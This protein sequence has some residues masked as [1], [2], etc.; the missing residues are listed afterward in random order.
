MQVKIYTDYETLSDK[1]ADLIVE[2]IKHKPDAVIC[3]ASGHTPLRTCQ[4]FAEKVIAQKV[5]ISKAGFVEL[6][7][8]VGVPPDNEGSC[9]YFLHQYIF[10]PLS[11]KNDKI[12]LFDA[13][14]AD[15]QN[16]CKKMDA[17]IAK[18]GGI[19]LMVVGIGMN[20]HI[21]F[22]E[23]GVSFTNYSHVINLDET[24]LSVGQKYFPSV[25]KISEGITLGFQHLINAKQ[26][27]LLANGE[28]KASV[29]QQTIEGNVTSQLPASILKTHANSVIMIDKPASAL[30]KNQ[31]Y[32]ME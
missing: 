5:N 18:L 30:L 9:S 15:L 2:T 10:Y 22:N 25:T 13:M 17:A 32:E 12:F 29:I 7:E 26:I 11:I 6:D 16:E 24:T 23:P 3:F 8:W 4:L 21:G 14:A 20:G 19:D 28:K 1:A 27:I 31:A